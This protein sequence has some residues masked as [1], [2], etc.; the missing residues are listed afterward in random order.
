MAINSLA[1]DIMLPA[2]QQIGSS[3]G[4][5]NENH[6][7]YV[8]SRLSD[9]LR[10]GAALLRSLV[11]SLRPPHTL[12]DR[13]YRLCHLGLRHCIDTLYWLAAWRFIQGLGSAATSRH[14]HFHRVR[15]VFSGRA[16]RRMMSLIMMV[17]MIVPVIAPGSGQV[18]M[19]VSTWHM[20]FV[21]IATM[22]TS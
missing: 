22:A 7:Q 10:L 19:L 11:G 1:I 21:F 3:L 20:I 2:L 4:V 17:F 8:V 16:I 14:H 9:R 6:Q 15:D 18:I 13:H 5:E 12:A